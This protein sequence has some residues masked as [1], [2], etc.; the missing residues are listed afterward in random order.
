MADIDPRIEKLPVWA[1]HLIRDQENLI[2]R[3]YTE[4]GALRGVALVEKG[5]PLAILDPYD[6]KIPVSWK[7]L[8][9]IRYGDF[10]LNYDALDVKPSEDSGALIRVMGGR[11]LR[12]IPSASNV[13]Y[14][15]LEDR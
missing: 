14:I 4:N 13:V 3:L 12:I 6:L 7:W 2:Q 8:D 9:T 10:E 5:E 15:G 1:R 11:S